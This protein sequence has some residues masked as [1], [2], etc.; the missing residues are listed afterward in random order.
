MTRD[1]S[2]AFHNRWRT[3]GPSP[4]GPK[5][6]K[7]TGK[8]ALHTF[9]QKI[10]NELMQFKMA[11][12]VNSVFTRDGTVFVVVGQ[13][14]RPQP[15]R[16]EAAVERIVQLLLETESNSPRQTGAPGSQ[17]THARGWTGPAEE[18][19]GRNT[20][21]A[22]DGLV[23]R[24]DTAPEQ[25]TGPP[26]HASSGGRVSADRDQHQLPADDSM[27]ATGADWERLRSAQAAARW[28]RSP[29]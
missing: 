6:N 18:T 20:P 2:R 14:D 23:Y 28:G 25:H 11:H 13:R 4:T 19:R 3:L 7:T 5:Q 17:Q 16:S 9:R 29:I 12:Q 27:T 24:G 26:R 10:V 8:R 1:K 22:E 15:V 21:R